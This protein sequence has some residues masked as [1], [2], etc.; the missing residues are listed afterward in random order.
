MKLKAAFVSITGLAALAVFAGPTLCFAQS[1][2][3]MIN[4]DAGN[5]GLGFSG[6]GGMATGAKLSSPN[7]LVVDNQGNL[8][9]VDAGNTRIRKVTPASVISTVAG[10]GSHGFSGDGGPATAASFSWG[11]NGHLGIAVDS[12]G[13]LYI[14]DTSNQRVRKVDT[15]G[16][17]STVAGSGARDNSGDGGAATSAGLVDPIAVVVD[18]SGNLYIA[19]FAGNRVRK[20]SPSGIITT[21]AGG[22]PLGSS[23]GDGGPATN[24]VLNAPFAV[25]L[26]PFGNL[27]IGDTTARRVRKVDT[28]GI[29]TTVAGNGSTSDTGDGGLATLAG[30]SLTGLAVDA[31]GNIF[32]SE[33][34]NRVREVNTAGMINTIAGNGTGGYSGDG[35]PAVSATLSQPGDVAVDSG[36]NLY[37]ADSLNMRIRKMLPLGLIKGGTPTIAE[38]DNAFS[39]LPNSPIQ[40][41]TWVA[42]KG[43]NLANTNPGR[44]WNANESFPTSMDGTSVTI[45]GK[46]A[47][48]YFVSPGQVNVQAPTDSALGPVSVVVTNNG[49]SSAAY[50]AT[51][52]SNSPALLQ[53]GGGQYP[54]ALI[55]NGSGFVGN[56]AVIPNTVSAHAGDSLTLWV[57]GLGPTTPALP[58]GQ[59]PTTFPAIATMPT[60]TAGGQS[61]TVLG[62]VLRYAGLYQVNVQLPGSLPSGDLPL[63]IIQ[64]SFQS[65]DGVMINVQ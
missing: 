40:S 32:I 35:G 28:N 55:T 56:P 3:G 49:V 12:S 5:G 52:Q 19:E 44:G 50:T 33:M 7:G 25:A 64:G 26:D 41:G 53:W 59:Q 24:A 34:S 29:I 17:I 46:T 4:T 63:K 27:Y 42:I 37:I 10:N 14:P 18:P 16:N 21:A 31:A 48:A 8:Y 61:V 6:D 62:G 23:N 54:Y 22:G 11:F 47:F 39:N 45:N 60:I 51:Y 20:V 65:P 36:G 9:I 58:A 43:T 2:P 57:T 30:F 13:N 15:S 1:T 38:V